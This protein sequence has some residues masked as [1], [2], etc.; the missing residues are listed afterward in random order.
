MPKEAS[1][2]E[3]A[4][5]R[6]KRE[7][8][9]ARQA[10]DNYQRENADLKKQIESGL[11]NTGIYKQYMQDLQALREEKEMYKSLYE[12]LAAKTEKPKGKPGRK[13]KLSLQEMDEVKQLRQEGVSLRKIALQYDCSLATIQRCLGLI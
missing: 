11:E 2:T 7:L 6:L 5:A 8:A 9:E 1:K 13:N 3:S 4:M 10:A 12:N